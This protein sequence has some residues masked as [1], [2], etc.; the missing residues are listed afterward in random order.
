[1]KI[2][3]LV[4]VF[5]FVSCKIVAQTAD[6]VMRYSQ[7][8]LYG[9]ARYTSM[10]GAF[11]ALGGDLSAI[12]SN[13]AG[14][15]VFN[16]NQFGLTLNRMKN[17]NE[18]NYFGTLADD[19]D[20]SF[21]LNQAGAVWVFENYNDKSNW[22]KF[23]FA[24]NYENTKNFDNSFY[25]TGLNP[26]NSIA[27][28]YIDYANGIPLEIIRDTNFED[29]NFREQQAHLAYYSFVIEPQNNS[30]SNTNYLS[31]VLFDGNYTQT[32]SIV[33]TGNNGKFTINFS[34][35]Y[36]DKWYFGFNFNTHFS[37]F[38]QS[39]IFVETNKNTVGNGRYIERTE[40]Y[41]SLSTKSNGVSMQFGTIYKPTESVRLGLTYDSPT[42]LRLEDRLTQSISSI[43]GGGFKNANGFD[44]DRFLTVDPALEIIYPEYDIRTPAKWTGSFAYVFGK[45]GL[46]SVDYALKDFGNSK[47]SPN[48]DF[49]ID[50]E[51]IKQTFRQNASE[52]R[53][54]GEYKIEKWSLRA[55]YRYV[56]SPYKNSL[57]ISNSNTYSGGLGYNFGNTKVDVSYTGTKRDSQQRFFSEFFNDKANVK[58]NIG[59]VYLTLLFEM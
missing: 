58:S 31:N 59:N 25:S 21:D 4:L 37:N 47:L 9:T 29:L 10:A 54:G 34:S 15:S 11:G 12:N 46:I 38:R 36:T 33:E 6:D 52:I 1:M 2:K 35:Q 44:V 55:G 28:Y 49:S 40:I 56:Q 41:N 14:S 26:D 3:N 19:N 42:W 13:P 51:E 53:L 30:N 5:A 50:N 43:N 18:S 20:T 22:K 16:N 48:S 7:S 45:K 27:N 8:N 17:C 39:S 32:S 24:L 23:S 57:T